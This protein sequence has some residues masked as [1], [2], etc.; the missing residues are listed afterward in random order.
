MGDY[1]PEEEEPV[2]GSREWQAAQETAEYEQ[3]LAEAIEQAGGDAYDH[4]GELPAWAQPWLM[5]A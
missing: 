1:R 3:A 2:K 5:A 4:L